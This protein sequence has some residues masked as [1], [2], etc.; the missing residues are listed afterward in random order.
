MVH[1]VLQDCGS[2]GEQHPAVLA[3]HQQAYKLLFIRSLSEGLQFVC[4]SSLLHQLFSP[5][6]TADKKIEEERAEILH[7]LLLTLQIESIN[8]GIALQDVLKPNLQISC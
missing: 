7:I 2:G 3:F 6:F 1:F 4:R 5:S 8:R